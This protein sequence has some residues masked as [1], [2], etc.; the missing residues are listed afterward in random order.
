MTCY[1]GQLWR[2]RA[3]LIASL[4]GPIVKT[5]LD[6]LEAQE[7]P[8]ISSREAEEIREKTTVVRDQAS[9]LIDM[10]LKKGEKAC[11]IFLGLLKDIDPLVYNDVVVQEEERE[12]GKDDSE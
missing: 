8:V 1:I 7:P 5:L 10:V 3:G 6:K 4:T 9:S 2:Y 11:N 12:E